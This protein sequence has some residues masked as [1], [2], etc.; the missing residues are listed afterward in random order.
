[1]KSWHVE[2][3]S[4]LPSE[5]TLQGEGED[6]QRLGRALRCSSE[7]AVSTARV[8]DEVPTL[9]EVNNSC[10]LNMT[11]YTCHQGQEA[12]TLQRVWTSVA[13]VSMQQVLQLELDE[14]P[15]HVRS[16]H[17]LEWAC[18]KCCA[19]VGW[20]PNLCWKWTSARVSWRQVLRPSWMKSQLMFEVNIS[21]S[22]PAA[23]AAPK[24]DEVP[25]HVRSEHRSSEHAVSTAK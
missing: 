16:E 11:I 22:E 13:Q 21:S 10:F 4:P 14:V 19:Q 5:V 18:G 15:T 8:L 20:S 2:W 1:M 12:L 7:R 6:E 23:S 9:F 17:Q 25:T 24:L 3:P